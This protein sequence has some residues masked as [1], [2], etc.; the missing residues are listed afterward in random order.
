[1]SAGAL[2]KPLIDVA[3]FSPVPGS[4]RSTRGTRRTGRI[5]RTFRW[6][7]HEVATATDSASASLPQLT[8]RYP[9]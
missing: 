6:F 2:S 1:M 3:F 7:R 4:P 9:Y 8:R 5:A